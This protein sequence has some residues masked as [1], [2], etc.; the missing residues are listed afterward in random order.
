[1]LVFVT[2]LVI[3]LIKHWLFTKYYIKAK[4]LYVSKFKCSHITY[5]KSTKSNRAICLHR[6]TTTNIM[7]FPTCKHNWIYSLAIHVICLIFLCWKYKEI[8]GDKIKFMSAPQHSNSVGGV[9]KSNCM[10]VFM[11]F[12][13]LYIHI[14]IFLHIY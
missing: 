9:C 6:N 3:K 10:Y 13:G 14:C 12:F 2:I 1:M 8:K 5:D 11:L 4:S 7:Y